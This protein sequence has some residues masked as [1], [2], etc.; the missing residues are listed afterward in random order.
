M[1]RP[2]GPIPRGGWFLVLLLGA[3]AVPSAA[4]AQ[5]TL[6]LPTQRIFSV[7]TVVSVPDGGSIQMGGIRRFSAGRIE[8]GVP[9][10]G[11]LPVANRLFRNQAIGSNV[12][13]GGT[14]MH[15]Q[16]LSMQEL[17]EDVMAE[18]RA[19]QLS[20]QSIDPNGSPE[21]QKKAGFIHRHVGRRKR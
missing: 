14:S 18:A 10:L 6:Q 13:G 5:I 19:R 4:E 16:I 11:N 21:I 1:T 3:I 17:E 9:G 8:R 15:V 2:D 20:R 7:Q 12:T